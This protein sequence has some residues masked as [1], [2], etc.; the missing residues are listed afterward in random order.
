MSHTH[1]HTYTHTVLTH[2]VDEENNAKIRFQQ[3]KSREKGLSDA[4]I[5]LQQTLKEEQQAFHHTT[6]EQRHAILTLKEELLEVKGSTS[7]DAQFRRKES[8]ASVKV[9]KPT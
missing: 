4:V 3:L 1:I 5:Q 2:R 6:T 9:F 8:Q 7:T